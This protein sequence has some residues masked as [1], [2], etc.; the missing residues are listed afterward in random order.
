MQPINATESNTSKRGPVYWWTQEIGEL[1]R[2]C[3]KAR[4]AYTKK[5]LPEHAREIRGL[6][7]KLARQT[8]R[9]AIKTSNSRC[10]KKLMEEVDDDI[11]KGVQNCIQ[12]HK[13]R[14]IPNMSVERNE[15][16]VTNYAGKLDKQLIPQISAWIG[17]SHGEVDFFTTQM[18][19][20]HGA[21][22]HTYIDLVYLM[23]LSVYT[24]EKKTM[25]CQK[26]INNKK[27]RH[28]QANRDIRVMKTAH[29]LK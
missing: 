27:D 23:G 29:L 25:T 12:A 3:L 8:L 19:S 17:R 18:L 2:E 9:V 5:N 10:W 15:H 24:V 6:N 4:R 28:E 1:R 20:G 16:V 22:E 11:W 13:N 26:D 21:L 7:Y 14:T